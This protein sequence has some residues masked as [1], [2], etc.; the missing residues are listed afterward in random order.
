MAARTVSSILYVTDFSVS[1]M[2]AMPWAISEAQKFGYHLS[3]LYP[4]RLDQVSKGDNVIQSKKELETDAQLKFD[5]LAAGTL[6]KSKVPFDFRS[7][8]GF[9]NDRIVE[10]VR[11]RHIVMM[12]MGNS[13][14]DGETLE[15]LLTEIDVPVVI[16]PPR[17]P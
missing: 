1:S 5:N 16:V 15:A 6:R 11:K 4:F 17:R 14:A 12:V 3:I 2:N 8:V 7:E 9:L 10:N 13:M